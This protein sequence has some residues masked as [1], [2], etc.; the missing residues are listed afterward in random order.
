MEIEI[1][2]NL[3]ELSVEQLSELR[4]TIRGRAEEL[5]AVELTVDTRDEVLA[6]LSTLAEHFAAV[7]GALADA[8]A[9]AQAAADKRS[10]LLSAFATD[11]PEVE[12]AEG[13]ITADEVDEFAGKAKKS[14]PPWM[15]EKKEKKMASDESEVAE[16]A[17]ETEAPAPAA[18]ALAI[19][20]EGLNRAVAEA[21]TAGVTA[22]L[23]AA[24]KPAAAPAAPVNVSA[25]SGLRPLVSMPTPRQ[26]D[27]GGL[28][29]A[30]KLAS[31]VEPGAAFSD[32]RE[33]AEVIHRKWLSFGQGRGSIPEGVHEDFHPI[34][35]STTDYGS[36]SLTGDPET[37]FPTIQRLRN[38]QLE[39]LVAS[40]CAPFP[41]M[42]DFF[43]LAEPQNPVE[44][45]LP[46]VNAPRGGIRFIVPPDW[47][48]AT[49]AIGQRSC[50]Q[51]AN[52]LTPAKPYVELECPEVQEVC[53]EQIS[54][55]VRFKNLNFRTFP[56]QIAAFMADVNVAFVQRKEQHLMNEI[57]GSSTAVSGITTGYGAARN[58]IYNLTVAG[59]SYRRRHHMSD[60]ARLQAFLPYWSLVGA[61]L[62][63]LVSR[64]DYTFEMA[65]AEIERSIRD[66][67]LLVTWYYEP[68]TVHGDQALDN[69]LGAT[70]TDFPD[71]VVA[72]LFAPGTFLRLDGGTLEVGPVRDSV[73]NGTNHLEMFME[74]WTQVAMLGLESLVIDIP[75]CVTGGA[76]QYATLRD[77]QVSGS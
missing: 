23:A 2:E 7:D 9:T 64:R 3:S 14:V 77:C 52:P 48:A 10:E 24:P 8:T 46:S 39:A 26:A 29:V 5:G 15:E 65:V 53:V 21:V 32:V 66:A 55:R 17:A 28:V 30:T 16:F 19:D 49:G 70:L 12:V 35:M 61:T 56:E 62:D 68:A 34:A 69:P 41:P 20:T 18:A 40:T 45:A 4:D 33:V 43:R 36:D 74:E 75:F 44:R 31:G 58:L 42:Y 25:L 37:D 72:Y 60:G 73:L 67:G 27:K 1:P 76:P 54:Q 63:I 22:A 11:A 38:G 51:D 57:N 59:V 13:E 71:H 47:T 6:E 50:A